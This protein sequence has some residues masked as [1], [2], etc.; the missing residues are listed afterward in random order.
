MDLEDREDNKVAGDKVV[1]KVGREDLEVKEDGARADQVAKVDQEV[2]GVR[3]AN[4]E[5]REVNKDGV[6]EVNMGKVALAVSKDGVR[7]NKED[8]E[9]SKE[10]GVRVVKADQEGKDGTKAVRVVK[11][12]QEGKDGTKEVRVDREDK[13]V[14]EVGEILE[15]ITHGDSKEEWAKVRVKT[16]SSEGRAVSSEVKVVSLEEISEW[17]KET[18]QWTQQ[19]HFT[20]QLVKNTRSF[21]LEVLDFLW[22]RARTLQT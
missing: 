21:Q 14:R 9:D 22:T 17:G 11:A 8:R 1:N 10:A 5:D 2:N 12:D 18:R 13:A 20:Q 4:K 15:E 19:S 3:V 6:K 7:V 16:I